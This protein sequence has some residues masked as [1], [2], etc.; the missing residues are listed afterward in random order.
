M[1]LKKIL[2]VTLATLTWLPIALVLAGGVEYRPPPPVYSGFYFEGSLGAAFRDWEEE[3]LVQIYLGLAQGGVQNGLGQF[4][5]G[6]AGFVYGFDM[7]YQWTRL[8]SG[9]IGWYDLSSMQYTVPDGYTVPPGN[10][11]K[12]RNWLAYIAL[13]FSYPIYEGLYVVAKLGAGYLDL[14]VKN[15]FIP[16][17]GL[18]NRGDFWAPLFA[19]GLQYYFNW[20][21]SINAQ[22][23]FMPGFTRRPTNGMIQKVPSPHSNIVTLGVGYKFAI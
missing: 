13:K 16:A 8:L 3:G 20:V 5:N 12:F 21:W 19:F 9:E 23:M 22:Y 15:S 1:S 10:T 7:G 4:K 2:T 6:K 14:R 11:M 17:L 18:P